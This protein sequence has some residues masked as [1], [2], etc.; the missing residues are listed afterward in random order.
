[1][2]RRSSPWHGTVSPLERL[3]R[4]W[5]H[6][7][8]FYSGQPLSLLVGALISRLPR[9]GGP[10]RLAAPALMALESTRPLS[11]MGS[12]VLAFAGPMLKLAF[13]PAEYDR[14]QRLLER[15]RSIDWIIEA[16]TDGEDRRRG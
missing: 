6:A 10:R 13:S 5:A 14:L 4:G 9:F 15:R 1:M 2:P 3:R 8:A 16:I 12:Q 7:F 11:F